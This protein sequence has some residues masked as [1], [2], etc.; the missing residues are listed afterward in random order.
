M[1]SSSFFEI[2]DEF[3]SPVH[4]LLFNIFWK[5]CDFKYLFNEESHEDQESS[6]CIIKIHVRASKNFSS[7]VIFKLSSCDPSPFLITSSW[8][9][10]ENV[11]FLLYMYIAICYGKQ[12]IRKI[13]RWYATNYFPHCLK[14]CSVRKHHDCHLKDI[15]LW[16]TMEIGTWHQLGF[17]PQF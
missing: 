4:D 15:K 13:M 1:K 17:T 3:S 5:V 12:N 10:L 7:L 6:S 9:I 14:Y 2:L 16:N 11:S 8:W